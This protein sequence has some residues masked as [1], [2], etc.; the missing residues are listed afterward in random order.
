M[1]N[2]NK[3]TIKKTYILGLLTSVTIMNYFSLQLATNFQSDVIKT[4]FF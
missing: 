3:E 4:Q 1:T 2:Y